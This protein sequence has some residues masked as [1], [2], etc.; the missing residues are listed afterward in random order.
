MDTVAREVRRAGRRIE[1][2]RTEWA[3]LQFFLEHPGQVLTRTMIF[4][5]VWGYD[6]D[7]TSNTLGVYMGYLRRKIEVE[8]EPR[9]L[10]TVRSIGYILRRS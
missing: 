2:T 7:S 9:L 6:F 3:L 4:E 1:L 5:R 8:D 10:H